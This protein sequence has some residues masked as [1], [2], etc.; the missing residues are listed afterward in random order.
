[1]TKVKKTPVTPAEPT[2]LMEGQ[3][4]VIAVR[5]GEPTV[6]IAGRPAASWD[7]TSTQE[8]PPLSGKPTVL[9]AGHP[10]VNQ[11]PD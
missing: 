7:A 8:H 2:V 1:M 4:A 6:L 9:V 10:A 3:P 5:E 11:K